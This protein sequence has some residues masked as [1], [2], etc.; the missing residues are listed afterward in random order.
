MMT[1]KTSKASANAGTAYT[2]TD[3]SSVSRLPLLLVSLSSGLG[4]LSISRL[5][6]VDPAVTSTGWG[7]LTEAGDVGGAEGGGGTVAVGSAAVPYPE[8]SSSFSEPA[9]HRRQVNILW[10]SSML[11]MSQSTQLWY[12]F[13]ALRKIINECMHTHLNSWPLDAKLDGKSATSLLQCGSSAD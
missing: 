12:S 2:R 7:L 11:S 8:P 13:K 4:V 3:D 9:K 6:S 1:S 5:P 10:V